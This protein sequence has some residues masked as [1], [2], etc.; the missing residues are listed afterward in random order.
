VSIAGAK[1]HCAAILRLERDLPAASMAL[2]NSGAI[3]E[4][5]ASLREALGRLER[6]MG[7]RMTQ[8]I[9]A[10]S[11]LEDVPEDGPEDGPEEQ[12]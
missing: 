12:G 9:V 3:M 2:P 5:A 7:E 4:A 6:F 10:A 1:R 11:A 8:E